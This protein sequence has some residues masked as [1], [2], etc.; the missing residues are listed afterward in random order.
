VNYSRLINGIFAVLF[1][2]IALSA[3]SFFV[4]MHREL[5]ALRAQEA[6]NRRKLA[7]AEARLREQ[8]Q[9][10]DRLR[11]DP[12]LVEKIIR[13]RF[14]YARPDEFVFRFDEEPAR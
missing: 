8:E 2:A 11:H 4:S 14:G 10:L 5:K 12:A 9:Y 3:V 1:A 7:A 13:E 6:A